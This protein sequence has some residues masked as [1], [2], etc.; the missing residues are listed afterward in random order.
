LL[1]EPEEP[2]VWLNAREE[3]QMSY[4]IRGTDLIAVATALLLSACGPGSPGK[5]EKIKPATVEHIDGSAISRVILTEKAAERLDI[6]TVPVREM[7]VKRTGALRRVV[8]YGAVL[9]DAGGATWVYT[10]PEPRTFVRQQIG[11]DYIDGEEAVLSDGPSSGTLV[12][13]VGA[14]ELFGTEFEIGH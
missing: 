13:T 8:P 12:V 1:G 9:Y 6:E 2:L 3:Y 7:V 11:V 4:S 14:S 10:S 5:V